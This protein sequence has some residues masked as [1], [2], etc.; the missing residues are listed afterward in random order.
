MLGC[1]FFF[2]FFFSFYRWTRGMS[3]NDTPKSWKFGKI[4]VLVLTH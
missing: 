2:L 4:S 3:E 1:F